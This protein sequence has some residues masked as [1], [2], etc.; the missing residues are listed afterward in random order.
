ME[1]T[2]N[3]DE[4]FPFAFP[5]SSEIRL[6]RH[7][8][9]HLYLFSVS[10][11]PFL[12]IL[13]ASLREWGAGLKKRM[14]RVVELPML[15]DSLIPSRGFGGTRGGG[16]SIGNHVPCETQFIIPALNFVHVDSCTFPTNEAAKS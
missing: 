7:E 9:A 2:H 6:V 12:E 10:G 1:I 14:L 11:F 8:V 5:R 4:F 3:R 16:F 13:A 15:P